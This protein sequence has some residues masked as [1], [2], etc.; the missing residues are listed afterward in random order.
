MSYLIITPDHHAFLT[1][2][3]DVDNH[4]SPG[5]IVIKLWAQVYT[6]DGVTWQELKEDSL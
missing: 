5:M 3:F 6:A 4:Y 2:W 1:N